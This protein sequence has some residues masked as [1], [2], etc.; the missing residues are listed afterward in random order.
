VLH[1]NGL[2][3]SAWEAGEGPVVLCLHGFPDHARSFRHQLPALA[4]AGYHAVAPTLRGY[5]PS[6]QPPNGGY[7]GIRLA[8]DVIGWL[9]D[10][11]AKQAHLIGHDWGA[12]IGYL[13]AALAPQRFLSLATLS[14]PHPGRFL[15]EA[16]IHRP[17][18]LISSSY[19]LYFQL[20]GIAE[21]KIERDDFAFLEALWRK[22]SPGW[23][24]PPDEMAALKDTFRQPG[25]VRASLGYYRAIPDFFSQA[26]RATFRL[27]TAKIPVPTLALT[28][29]LDGCMDTRLHDDLTY[30][31][32]FPKGIEIARVSNAGHFLHQEK[33]DDVTPRLLRWIRRHS[34][35]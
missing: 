31:E 18:Q 30:P 35:R 1:A 6:S 11:G 3:F 17:R 16:V 34:G 4:S 9:D 24:W 13:A 14:V 12:V 23:S 10:L 5:E 29:E 33:P 21:R 28:G 19:I 20:R 27:Q 22:W 26:G 8:E 2:Q 25:V 15:R 7:Q 32:D